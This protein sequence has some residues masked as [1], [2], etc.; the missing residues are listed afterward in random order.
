MT[1][2]V[3]TNAISD[4]TGR[5]G[6]EIPHNP[7]KIYETN[8]KVKCCALQG[9]ML[10]YGDD[11]KVVVRDVSTGAILHELDCDD[12]VNF[13][14]LEGNRLLYCRRDKEAVLVFLPY[15]PLPKTLLANLDRYKMDWVPMFRENPRLMHRPDASGA[16][17]MHLWCKYDGKDLD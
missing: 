7:T 9:N 11:K 13:C 12:V 2:V 15:S 6:A 16:T 1:K 8:H 3:P 17:L 5:I 14:A 10:V 4:E